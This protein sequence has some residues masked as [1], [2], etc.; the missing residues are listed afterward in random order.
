MLSIVPFSASENKST[1]KLA[2]MTD[3]HLDAAE[4]QTIQQF[5]SKLRAL[6][7]DIILIGGDTC[8]GQKALNCM[9]SIAH[10]TGKNVYFVLGNHEFYHG[11]IA[12]TR[13]LAH[14]MTKKNNLLHYLTKEALIKLTPTTVLIGH[15]G[16]SDARAGNFMDSTIALHD[17]TLINELKNLTKNELQTRLHQLG[18]QAAH[19]IQKK[20]EEAF[21]HYSNIILLTHTPPFQAAC[22]YEKHISDDNWAPHFVCKAMGDVLFKIMKTHPAKQMI[23]LCGHAHHMA[24]ISILPNL[25]VMVGESTLGFPEIQG[26]ICV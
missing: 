18:S 2:W 22:I 19:D 25:R 14:Q 8:N 7:S 24:D 13:E 23:V 20:V 11:S 12:Q 15:D 10:L 26:L 3:L 6:E 1:K 17:Y 16:W 21:K 5:L 9:E 4:Y